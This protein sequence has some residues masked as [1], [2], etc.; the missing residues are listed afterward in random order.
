MTVMIT[1]TVIDEIFTMWSKQSHPSNLRSP[2]RNHGRLKRYHKIKYYRLCCLY[3]NTNICTE[4]GG[5]R[6]CGVMLHVETFMIQGEMNGL[7]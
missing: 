4:R 3:E 7:Y 5:E 1:G 6:L 2:L